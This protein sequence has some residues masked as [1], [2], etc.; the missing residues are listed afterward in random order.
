MASSDEEST[1][2]YSQD[3]PHTAAAVGNE[4]SPTSSDEGNGEAPGAANGG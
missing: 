1:S 2:S 3:G 4:D